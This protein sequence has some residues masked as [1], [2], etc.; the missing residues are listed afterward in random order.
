MYITDHPKTIVPFVVNFLLEVGGLVA[1]ILYANSVMPITNLEFLLFAYVGLVWVSLTSA[2][3]SLVLLRLMEQAEND[4]PM[5]LM[6]AFWL[7]LKSDFLKSFPVV[8]VWSALQLVIYV[9]VFLINRN[10]RNR[11]RS[12][13]SHHGMPYRRRRGAFGGKVLAANA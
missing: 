5:R 10:H 13:S 1:L 8:L 4:E 7:A 3:A 2:L 11:S 12:P 6:R 9:M